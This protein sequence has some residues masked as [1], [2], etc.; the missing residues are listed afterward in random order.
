[1]VTA[2]FG[3]RV[4]ATG[5]TRWRPRVAVA[6]AVVP[7]VVKAGLAAGYGSGGGRVRQGGGPVRWR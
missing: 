3:R 2:G 4:A 7:A 6:G 5:G 1:M